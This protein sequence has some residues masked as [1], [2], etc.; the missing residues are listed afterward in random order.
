MDKKTIEEMIGR[1]IN[2]EDY[3]LAVSTATKKLQSIIQRYGDAGG[4]RRTPWYLAELVIEALTQKLFSDVT[5]A[6]A[7]ESKGEK[8]I[9]PTSVFKHGCGKKSMNTEENQ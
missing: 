1:E 4:V 3:Q 9:H 8:P 5:I 7:S 2:E 6:L